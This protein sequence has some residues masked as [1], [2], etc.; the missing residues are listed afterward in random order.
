MEKHKTL[1]DILKKLESKS[2][3]NKVE[4]VDNWDG[5]LCANWL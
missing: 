2:D 3:L 4:F 1:I 5:D